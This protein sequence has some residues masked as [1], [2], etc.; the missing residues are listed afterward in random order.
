MKSSAVRIGVS[1]ILMVALL[2]FFL[3]NVDFEEMMNGL[4]QAN[5]WLIALAAFL[6]LLSYF[7]RVIRWMLILRPVAKVRLSSA[8]DPKLRAHRCARAPASGWP[9][10]PSTAATRPGPGRSSTRHSG[11]TRVRP[12][13]GCWR[14]SC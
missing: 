3:W 2:A 6:A 1:L 13:S 11:M 8:S 7:A 14:S 10:W 9:R 12:P 4:A 5:V